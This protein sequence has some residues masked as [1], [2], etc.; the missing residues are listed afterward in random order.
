MFNQLRVSTFLLF[1][2]FTF[3]LLPACTVTTTE[4]RVIPTSVSQ[5]ELPESERDMAYESQPS[6]TPEITLQP[7][8]GR[9]GM[10]FVVQGTGF[11]PNTAVSIH[12]GPPNVGYTWENYGGALTNAQG[13]VS[14]VFQMPYSWSNGIAVTEPE[15]V[16]VLADEQGLRKA[17]A[18]VNLSAAL[19]PSLL[20]SPADVSVGQSVELI[21]QGFAPNAS[22]AIRLGVPNTGLSGE[23]VLILSA[24]GQG[25]FNASL[26]LP[27]LW[28]G[29]DAAIVE[30]DLIVAVVD[31]A[32]NQTIATANLH[33]EP[34]TLTE[35][36]PQP[37]IC[38]ESVL[39]VNEALALVTGGSLNVRTGPGVGYPIRTTVNQ[40]QGMS[41]LGRSSNSQ[42]VQVRLPGG[43]EGWVN[44]SYIKANVAVSSLVMSDNPP[45]A[46]TAVPTPEAT[47]IPGPVSEPLGTVIISQVDVREQPSNGAALITVIQKDQGM[48]LL[49][50]TED[51]SWVHVQLPGGYKGW[52]PANAITA[53][54]QLGNLPVT[55]VA[56]SIEAIGTLVFS[57]ANVYQSASSSAAIVT[58]ITGGQAMTLLGRTDDHQWIYVQLPG[59]YQGWIEVG[60]LQ[61]GFN[62]TNLPV[63]N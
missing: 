28:P 31:M 39:S 37:V 41:L 38:D 42:W 54:V 25:S 60:M 34:S 18:T 27:T 55:A 8:T 5:P 7:N 3:F 13:N 44:A 62:I 49:G 43:Y 6:L 47:E 30:T 50:R 59:G 48:T 12:L 40:C 52:L 11:T 35:E 61:T 63:K 58:T 9:P 16:V 32:V 24:D 56:Q 33:N 21:G 46:P 15:I 19:Q 17:M 23:D 29:T 14:L 53:N 26:T 2:F 4:A 36:L 22:V 10:Q 20:I 1:L 57:Q 51:S 45:P